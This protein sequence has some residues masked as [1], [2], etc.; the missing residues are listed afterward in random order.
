MLYLRTAGGVL[1]VVTPWGLRLPTALAV[2][3][4]APTVA[5]GVQPGDLVTVGDGEVALPRVV[6]RAVRTW[7]P[8][9]VPTADPGALARAGHVLPQASRWRVPARELTRR[10][11]AGRGVERAVG[12]LVGA[13]AGLTPSGDDVLCGVLL[14][15][16]LHG[17]AACDLAPTL[18][19]AVRPRLGSTTALSAALLR[20][21]AQGYAVAPVVRLAEAL[22]GPDVQHVPAAVAAVLAV[23]HSSGADLLA[24]LAGALEVL[25]DDTI[26]PALTVRNIL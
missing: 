11:L 19:A 17:S 7:H 5:W 20:E 16:R 15:L 22:V 3:T 24:G 2:A 6:V 12:A 23:G 10:L 25:Q 14:G 4:E 1:P 21:A 26:R 9:R 13:G 8:T 18:W